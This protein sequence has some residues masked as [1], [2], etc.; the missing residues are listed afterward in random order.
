MTNLEEQGGGA[1]AGKGQIL[2]PDWGNSRLWPELGTRS[3]FQGLLT[4]RRTIFSHGLITF[5]CSFSDFPGSL[6]AQLLV[7]QPVVQ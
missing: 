2:S 1:A 5:N 4:A 6:V 3:F 7:A